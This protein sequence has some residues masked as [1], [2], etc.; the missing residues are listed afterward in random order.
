MS[1]RM[2]ATSVDDGSRR[3]GRHRRRSTT[4][5]DAL[6]A[7]AGGLAL[8][9]L[10][11]LTGAGPGVAPVPA[12]MASTTPVGERAG[13]VCEKF[14]STP[15]EGGRYEVQN[16]LWG[17]DKPQCVVAFDTGFSVEAK[18]TNDSG[19]ASYPS[20]VFGCNYGNCT[21]GTPFPRPIAD[22]GDVRSSWVTTTPSSGDH[23]VAY[24][25]WLDPTA[26]KDG[27]P[28]GLELM[29]WLKH[30][31]RVQ[32]IGKKTGETTLGGV[33]Y[34][35]W[36]GKADL[37]T[38]S[39]VRKEQTNEVKDL[40]ITSFVTDAKNRGQA[41]EGWFLTSIQAGFE[42]WIGGDGLKTT[43]YSVTRNGQ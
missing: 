29:I 7:L 42:P 37:P 26:R 1:G 23:A 11:A 27:R 35:V 24:D 18:H 22:L 39:Y 32:P 6:R 17:S 41:K 34:E 36:L 8:V 16:S 31:D 40:D 13:K 10:A 19:P 21:K 12:A 33:A 15:V 4:R 5:G 20:I 38:I 30:T 14:G 25:I 9:A 3:G 43:S 2:C 28:T